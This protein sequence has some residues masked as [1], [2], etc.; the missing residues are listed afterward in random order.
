MSV[1]IATATQIF[2]RCDSRPP[3]L[4]DIEPTPHSDPARQREPALGFRQTLR[5]IRL[6]RT[7]RL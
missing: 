4:S 3:L 6:L 2:I 5:R 1:T 7:H